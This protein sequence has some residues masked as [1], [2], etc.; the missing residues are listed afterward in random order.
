MTKEQFERWRYVSEAMAQNAWPKITEQ[1]RE[2]LLNY[3]GIFLDDYTDNYEDVTRWEDPPYPCDRLDDIAWE[4]DLLDEDENNEFIFSDQY[5]RFHSAIRAGINLAT[6]TG[7]GVAGFTKNDLYTIFDDEV[8]DWI[9][10]GW[11][12]FHTDE[13]TSWD[14]MPDETPIFL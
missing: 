8:P 4:H 9:K 3:I 12:N 11:K 2:D 7:P 14:E 6:D 5:H 10:T 13:P 1:E